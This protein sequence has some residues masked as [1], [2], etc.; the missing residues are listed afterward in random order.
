MEDDLLQAVPGI[1]Q[2]LVPKAYELRIVMMG[3]HAFCAKINSQETSGGKED[4][5]RA[6]D[7][8]TMEPG[9]IPEKLR[10]QYVSLMERLGI[11]FGCIDV[12]VTPGGRHVFLEI[13][14]AGQFLFIEEYSG[15]PLLDAFSEFLLQG[16][17]D[18]DWRETSSTMHL[19]DIEE[20]VRDGVWEEHKKH[21]QTPEPV[22]DEDRAIEAEDEI[23]Q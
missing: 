12:I 18:F 11:V 2:E 4:W 20:E 22:I 3:E 17:T 19:A 16:R 6:Y 1:Y 7:E 8:L 14:Q 9:E 23:G 13:N 5:R 21:V 10:K 15:I